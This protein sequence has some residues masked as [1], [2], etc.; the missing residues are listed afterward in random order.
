MEYSSMCRPELPE[1]EEDSWN[2]S[3]NSVKSSLKYLN[4]LLTKINMNT[5]LAESFG[6]SN[7]RV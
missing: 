5:Y 3:E 4:E 6:P 7:C 2:S 1:E